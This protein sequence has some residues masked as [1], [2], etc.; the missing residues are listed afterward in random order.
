V[1]HVDHH[2]LKT[3]SRLKKRKSREEESAKL[4]ATGLYLALCVDNIMSSIKPIAGSKKLKGREIPAFWKIDIPKII[5]VLA[6]HKL[7]NSRE[8]YS[9]KTFYTVRNSYIALRKLKLQS[10]ETLVTNIIKTK[11][12]IEEFCRKFKEEAGHLIMLT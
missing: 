6:E 3:Q 5:E 8:I 10:I 1:R 7:I 9:D 4:A 2:N 11:Q 12:N